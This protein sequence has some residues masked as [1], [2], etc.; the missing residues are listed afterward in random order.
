MIQHKYNKYKQKYLNL[1]YLNY[2]KGTGDYNNDFSDNLDIL[3]EYF[4]NEDIIFNK[5]LFQNNENYVSI[6]N[7]FNENYYN[8]KIYNFNKYINRKLK[9]KENLLLF[10]NENLKVQFI[11]NCY[12]YQY[13]MENIKIMKK[14]IEK[15]QDGL[16]N[17][18]QFIFPYLSY[19]KDKIIDD[20]YNII[21]NFI[22]INCN[23]GIIKNLEVYICILSK[24]FYIY[25]FYIFVYNNNKDELIGLNK[26]LNENNNIFILSYLKDNNEM[27]NNNEN[28]ISKNNIISII[29]MSENIDN[30]IKNNITI[31]EY[32]NIYKMLD[33]NKKYY[34]IKELLKDNTIMSYCV[35]LLFLYQLIYIN[36]NNKIN[37][38]DEYILYIMKNYNIDNNKKI[39][40][41]YNINENTK[42]D[43]NTLIYKIIKL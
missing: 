42:N 41:I 19:N 5:T 40:K 25:Y 17:M 18:L 12:Y 8:N 13:F 11:K 16:S 15:K 34:C 4:I 33:E 26:E 31:N 1:K 14:Y 36:Q 22:N 21:N 7:K 32:I 30:I 6:M 28:F 20:E 10:N 27:K 35:Y 24:L 3:S 39:M 43:D 9:E 38:I 37:N 29:K 2:G 23:E